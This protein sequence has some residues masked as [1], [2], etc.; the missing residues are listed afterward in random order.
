[1]DRLFEALE[2]LT[3]AYDE[4][5]PDTCADAV[6]EVLDAYEEIRERN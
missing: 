5:D 3:L 4:G 2:A 1:M 6:Q